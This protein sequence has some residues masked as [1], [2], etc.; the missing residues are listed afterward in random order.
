VST[1]SPGQA[2]RVYDRIGR[3]QDWQ[4]FYEDAA[5]RELV[6]HAALGEAHNIFEL[7]C[8]TGRF[9]AGLFAEHLPPVA[10]YLGVDVSPRMLTLASDRL[11]PWH[12]RA[13]VAMAAG[14][15]P[16]VP[17]PNG[18]V[19]RF[20]SNYVFDLLSPEATR[21]ALDEARRVLAPG[22]LL[23][24]T[25]LTPGERGLARFV[26]RAWKDVWL[27]WPVLVGGCRP[28]RVVDALD[29]SEWDVRH[30]RAV[31][32]WGIASEAVIASPRP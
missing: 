18:S 28:V 10:R 26:S 2:R 3:A 4:R 29:P 6:A 31:V 12:D 1:L 30:R 21:D 13:S 9:A 11:R 16:R 23:C 5:T 19:D 14:D 15:E 7:G 32:A 17:M 22:G 20:V 27:R 25:G 24:A 8:G